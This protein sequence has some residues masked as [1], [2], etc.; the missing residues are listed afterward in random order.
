MGPLRGVL[1]YRTATLVVS[2]CALAG[3]YMS[4]RNFEFRLTCLE[5][6][7]PQA[8]MAT[9]YSRREPL[10]FIRYLSC[11]FVIKTVLKNTPHTQVLFSV[12]VG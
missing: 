11:C 6:V 10:F 2:K 12:I 3:D 8:P 9:A 5:R 7:L 1:F 4:L